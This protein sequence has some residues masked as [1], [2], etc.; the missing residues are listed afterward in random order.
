MREDANRERLLFTAADACGRGVFCL[1]LLVIRQHSGIAVELAGDF[2]K[3]TL[4][5]FHKGEQMITLSLQKSAA[6]PQGGIPFAGKLREMGDAAQRH[7]G[8]LQADDQLQTLEIFFLI[9]AVSP[10]AA[11]DRRKQPFLFIVAES[12]L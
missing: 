5:L 4:H 8:V 3:M 2:V 10:R 9:A 11:A 6:L 7:A 12:V 1:L